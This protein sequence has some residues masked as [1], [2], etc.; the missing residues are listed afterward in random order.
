M[1][2]DK[3]VLGVLSCC[4]T[5]ALW[6]LWPCQFCSK[7]S[8]VSAYQ[9]RFDPICMPSTCPEVFYGFHWNCTAGRWM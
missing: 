5:Q 4:L 8:F 3:Y 2:F 6:G 1:A 9:D 7:V